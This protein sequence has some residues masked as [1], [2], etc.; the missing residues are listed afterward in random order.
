MAML[1]TM[2]PPLEPAAKACA[3]PV[4]VLHVLP[5]LAGGGMELA[6]VRLIRGCTGAGTRPSPVH[7]L[8]I[9]KEAEIELVADC[10]SQARIWV[11]GEGPDLAT[12][13]C[14]W[15]R[16]RQVIRQNIF[17]KLHHNDG[18]VFFLAH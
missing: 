4:R 7:G 15:W 2:I 5:T 12:R 1:S 14:T 16:L 13:M 10:Q 11:F 18:N 9:L 3:R 6:A 17:F 8:C